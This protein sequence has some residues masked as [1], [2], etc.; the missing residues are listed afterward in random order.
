MTGISQAGTAIPVYAA[1]LCAGAAVLL[2]AGGDEGRR[3]AGLLL[4]G[5][6]E[7]GHPLAASGGGEGR[8]GFRVR[9]W[10][11][12]RAGH[13]WWCLVGGA[14]LGLAGESWLPVAAGAAAV[15]VVA[16]LLRRRVGR[17]GAERR[18]AAVVELC[19]AVSGE[20]RAGRQPDGALLSAG[21]VAVRGLQDAGSSLLA[22]AR[23]GGDVP[24][25]LREAA[26][27]PGAAGLLG[28]A[29]CWQVSV[30]GGAGLADGLDRV[31]G[32]LRAERDQREDLRAQLAGPR[33][34]AAVLA[35]LPGF[36]LLLGSAMGADPL[37]VLLHTPA[38]WGCLTAGGLLEWAG[39]AWVA[40]LVRSAEESDGLA[41]VLPLGGGLPARKG[42][43]R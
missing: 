27:M 19:A 38:G 31:A 22:A 1:L 30:E 37:R 12:G 25:A 2:T 26:R 3:R 14:V 8:A 17:V 41:R 28:V 20:L 21:E 36:G 11:V 23:F 13:E 24:A 4:A 32:A 40:R 15:P 6:G 10:T 5:V 9:K 39:L 43:S 16:R 33:S 29:A 42:G 35:L 34:T 7:A 18:E